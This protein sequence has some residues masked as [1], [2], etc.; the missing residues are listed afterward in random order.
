MKYLLIAILAF[1]CS[2]SYGQESNH[3]FSLNW[4][5]KEGIQNYFEGASYLESDRLNPRYIFELPSVNHQSTLEVELDHFTTEVVSW[6]VNSVADLPLD[7]LLKSWVEDDKGRKRGFVEVST[8]RNINGQIERLSSGTMRIVQVAAPRI[9]LRGAGNKTESVL[10]DGQIFKLKITETGIH[11]ITGQFISDN[12]GLSLSSIDPSKIQIFGNAGGRLPEPNSDPRTD[13]LEEIPTEGFGLEDGNLD[14]EDY[15]IFYTEEAG[16]WKKNGDMWVY[17]SNIYDDY[18]YVFLKIGSDDRSEIPPKSNV[19]ITDHR[20]TFLERQYYGKDLLNLLG[21]SISHQGSGKKWLSDEISNTRSID[22]SEEFSTENFEVG[23]PVSVLSHFYGRYEHTSEYELTIG[24]QQFKKIIS[25][26][27]YDV[28]STYAKLGVIRESFVTLAPI[29]EIRID[30]A[31]TSAPSD[32]WVDFVNINFKSKISTDNSQFFIRDTF[33]SN[34]GGFKFSSAGDWR[35]WDVTDIHNVS[36]IEVDKNGQDFHFAVNDPND[37][38][39]CVFR[40]DAQFLTPEV[41]GITENQNLHALSDVDMIIVTPELFR[42]EAER[43]SAHRSDR[44]G[45]KISVIDI[46]TVYNEFSSG[47]Q[48]PSALRDFCKMIYNRNPNFNYL[49]LFGDGSYDWRHAVKTHEDQNFIPVYETEESFAPIFAYP[50]DD[51]YALLSDDEGD[52]QLRGALDIATGRLICRS[53]DEARTMVDKI[54]RYETNPEALGDWRNRLIYLAD[55][56]D[57][58]LHI[59]QIEDVAT[60][61]ASKYPVYNLDKIYFDAYEQISTPGGTRYPDAKESINEAI[62]KGGLVM[63]YLGHGGPTGLAQERVLQS[64]DIRAWSNTMNMPVIMTATCSFTAFDEPRITSAG[65]YTVLN[66]KGGAIAI[67]STVR[68][69][70]AGDNKVLTDAAHDFL[71]VKDNDGKALPLG[72]VM[73]R[74]KNKSSSGD[75]SNN[76][77]FSLFGD[78]S[79][80]LAIPRYNVATTSINGVPASEFQDTV[81]ALEKITVKGAV[82]DDRGNTLTSFNGLV[83]PTVYDKQLTL[84]TKGQDVRSYVKEFELRK[85]VIFKGSASVI[86]GEFEFTFVIPKDINYEIGLG[87]ISYYASDGRETDANGL[88]ENIN[89][90]GV[91]SGGVTDDLGPEVEVYMNNEDFVFGGITN[92]DPTLFLKLSD[93]NGINVVGNSIGHDLV[94]VL[95]NNTQGAFILNDFYEATTDDFTAGTV[96]YPLKDLEVGRHYLKVTAWDIA[97][98]FT[99]GYTE[100]VVVDD[101]KSGLKHVLNYPNPFSTN[102]NFQFEHNLPPGPIDIVIQIFSV[103]GRLAKTIRHSGFSDGFRVDNIQWDGTDDFGSPIAKGVYL[104]KIKVKADVSGTDIRKESEFE[105]LVILK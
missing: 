63:V 41:V 12:L 53:T 65:E 23:N 28:E 40:M 84:K 9:G 11:K 91:G 55:D 88:Y 83:I 20:T 38:E 48:D 16:Q 94:A 81:G 50:T 27:D 2:L 89:I 93:D 37:R 80:R 17:E 105:R 85:N 64:T 92:A 1:F 52:N 44:D 22:L 103:S 54:I 76:R 14:T 82:I 61:I 51:Y 43:L 73:R 34:Q 77:K 19:T 57:S 70:Y 86:N 56:E 98:N 7:F 96:R 104:Y 74:A 39:F 87:K 95:D 99:E 62:F 69:V 59:N 21:R 97:N 79:M 66:D 36:K 31:Q 72:E 102:T 30:Y 68:A 25:S 29:E 24:D 35:V 100:F 60:T 4:L 49:L 90:G 101:L 58:N 32:G 47:R 6:D 45:F 71:Y 78:P 46:Q 5:E 75:Q 33:S 26:T 42:S 13:D 18:N 3:S 15:L 8:I 67:L 10:M